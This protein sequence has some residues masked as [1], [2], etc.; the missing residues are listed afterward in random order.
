MHMIKLIW[1][2]DFTCTAKITMKSVNAGNQVLITYIVSLIEHQYILKI[3]VDN[4]PKEIHVDTS[5][6]H[7]IITWILHSPKL[8]LYASLYLTFF[9]KQH[10]PNSPQLVR[11]IKN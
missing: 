6:L 3:H 4:V 7:R 1:S 9:F 11:I 10:S 2:V 5:Y 8:F